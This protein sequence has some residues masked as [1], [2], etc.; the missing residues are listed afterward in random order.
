SLTLNEL[1][2]SFQELKRELRRGQK[3]D[4][5]GLDACLMSMAEVC[6]ELKDFVEILIGSEGYSPASGWPYQEILDRLAQEPKD[7]SGDIQDRVAIGIVE[8]YVNFYA[9]YW[10]GGLS[11]D[12]SALKLAKADEL[13]SAIDALA[14][15]LR[16]KLEVA[17]VDQIFRDA[18]ILA[19]WEAQS[20]NGEQFVDLL[21]FCQL[22]MRRYTNDGIPQLCQTILDV[23]GNGDNRFVLKSCYNGPTYQYSHGVS[24]YFPWA[25]VAPSYGELDFTQKDSGWAEFLRVYTSKTRRMPRITEATSKLLN[26]GEIVGFESVN[27][28]RTPQMFRKTDDKGTGNAVQSMR[29]PPLFALPDDCIRERAN[30]IKEL[31]RFFAEL[32]RLQSGD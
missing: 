2:Q 26:Q 9:D 13:K 10:L 28:S 17:P 19:H 11:V 20:Y 3:I 21:D 5:L 1:K 14:N 29:N 32:L 27:S 8:E 7:G 31:E 18:L 6:Y 4:I 12:Q 22:L 24:I 30:I 23:I 15:T 25:Q 16:E